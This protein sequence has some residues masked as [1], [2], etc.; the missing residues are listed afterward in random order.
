LIEV[1]YLMTHALPPATLAVD[2]GWCACRLGWSMDDL[3][4]DL[5]QAL[6]IHEQSIHRINCPE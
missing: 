6:S 5:R 1:P 3:I 4:A 2:A